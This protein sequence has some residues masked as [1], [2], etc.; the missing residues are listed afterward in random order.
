MSYSDLENYGEGDPE[1]GEN[2]FCELKVCYPY[3]LPCVANSSASSKI[4][5][6]NPNLLLKSD[7]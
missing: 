7:F 5:V 2:E 6:P 1:N 4:L 3:L